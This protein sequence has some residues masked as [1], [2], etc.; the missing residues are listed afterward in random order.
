[1][2]EASAQAIGPAGTS[3]GR[4][5]LIPAKILVADDDPRNLL[6][7]EQIL[8]APGYE[9]VSVLSGEEA[10]RQV[11]RDDFAVILLDVQMPTM[12]GYEVANLIRSRPRSS[13]V[14]IIFLTAYNKDELHVFRG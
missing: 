13:H 5:S 14:P 10:L 9:L 8:E 2:I 7:L 3:L 4:S 11:L 12:D 6:A 1:M